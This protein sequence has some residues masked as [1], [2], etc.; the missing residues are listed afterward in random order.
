MQFDFIH[1]GLGKCMSTTLQNI[2]SGSS[3][4]HYKS[5]APIAQVANRLVQEHRSNLSRMPLF[6]ITPEE[7]P[8]KASVLSSEIFAFSFV[9]EPHNAALIGPKQA[10]IAQ[11]L[12]AL[13]S[14]VLFV[15]RD[16]FAWIRSCHGQSIH[17][18]GYE[19]AAQFLRVQRAVVIEN[20]NL[21]RL[22]AAWRQYGFRI[23]VLPMEMYIQTPDQFWSVYEA[24]LDVPIPDNQ[25]EISGRKRNQSHRE[26]LPIAAAIN[27]LQHT[28]WGLVE[29]GDGPDKVAVGDALDVVRRWGTRRA[30][31]EA[32]ADEILDLR[33]RVSHQAEQ[34]FHDFSLDDDLLNTLREHYVQPLRGFAPMTDWVDQYMASLVRR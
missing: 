33:Q 13:S 8:Q 31:E 16:P 5:G 3:N 34:E 12:K 4:T 29:R 2:W 10:Y 11:G 18:G 9:N 26:T 24:Q 1:A 19:N 21:S 30:L 7:G 15:V 28:L 17:Q 32:R 22:F 23:V 27:R 14:T 25:T 6:N 20:M